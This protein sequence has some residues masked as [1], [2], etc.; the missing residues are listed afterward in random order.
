MN[1]IFRILLIFLTTLL[2]YQQPTAVTGKPMTSN[3]RQLSFAIP[4]LSLLP[5][6]GGAGGG[7]L[8][9]GVTVTR[10]ILRTVATVTVGSVRTCMS[11][12]AAGAGWM[13][14]GRRKRR[15]LFEEGVEIQPTM[16]VIKGTET[17][18]DPAQIARLLNLPGLVNNAEE[19]TDGAAEV[20]TTTFIPGRDDLVH[21]D[22]ESA[23]TTMLYPTPMNDAV[24][25]EGTTPGNT[26]TPLGEFWS[27]V[28]EVEESE[29]ARLAFGT[30]T[31]SVV[32]LSLTGIAY[33]TIQ[34]TT[35]TVSYAGC[36]PVT[37]PFS[38]TLC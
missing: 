18:S 4:G 13:A 29:K 12:P 25:D 37:L 7:N 2:N 8:F 31:T 10:T 30:T 3:A 34:G 33:S 1:F 26:E 9:G 17:Y 36:S 20:P 23:V 15:G 35:L 38:T 27:H 21:F 19:T 28:N 32:T 16:L 14:C 5:G 24:D 6:G 22:D 11:T